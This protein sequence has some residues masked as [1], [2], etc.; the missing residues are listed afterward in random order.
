MLVHGDTTTSFAA[1]LASFYQGI[2]VG[3]VEAGL[4]TGNLA[5]PWPEEFNRRSVDLTADLLWAPTPSAAA[6]LRKEGA[7]SD[8]IILSG[9]TVIDA[10]CI[11]KDMIEGDA[12]LR[13]RIWQRLPRVDSRR[14]LIL[15]TGHRR[16]SFKSGL[17]NV[18]RALRRLAERSDVEIIWP[19][20][21]NPQVRVTVERELRPAD[22]VHLIAPIDYLGF[23][24]LMMRSHL[25]ISDSGGIQEEAPTLLKPVLVTRDETERPEAVAAGTAVLVGTSAKR[26]HA[27]ATHLLD[28]ASAYARMA[29]LPNPFGDGRA[30]VRIVDSLI[31]RYGGK[32]S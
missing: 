4:R 20:H 12:A 23:V 26:I 10:L 31:A 14:R 13:D 22:N 30:A 19:L 9:N 24:A 27:T 15:V 7:K 21:P 1:A 18:C 3:H 29:G 32:T 5:A 2:P 25:I 28:D 8:R 16:E 17:A 11:A 6:N